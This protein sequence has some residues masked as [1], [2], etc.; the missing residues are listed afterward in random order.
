VRTD[1]GTFEMFPLMKSIAE[2]ATERWEIA[3]VEWIKKAR[4][5]SPAAPEEVAHMAST[6]A[7]VITGMCLSG[8]CTAGAIDDAV[9]LQA[10]GVHTVTLTQENFVP[11]ARAYAKAKGF[12]ELELLVYPV[13]SEG[14]G[15]SDP[16]EF[17]R[18]HFADLD[19][20]MFRDGA[21]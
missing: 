9:S 10:M 6:C 3:G 19:R 21:E 16:A 14:N 18:E 2:A 7:A 5:G 11:L 4:A 15:V 17:V 13:P 1:A 8:G 20:K 12:A